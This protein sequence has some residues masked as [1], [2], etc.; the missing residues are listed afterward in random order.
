MENDYI[1]RES[2][3]EAINGMIIPYESRLDVLKV[4]DEA[5]SI[6]R[7]HNTLRDDCSHVFDM[8]ELIPIPSERSYDLCLLCKNCG[9]LTRLRCSD[10]LARD[11]LRRM[12]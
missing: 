2:L 7:S 6:E 4:I 10:G 9:E 5:P 1:N 12:L 3:K 11:F 8:W